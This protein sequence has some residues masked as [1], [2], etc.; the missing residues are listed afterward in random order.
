[1]D[2]IPDRPNVVVQFLGKGQR[3]AHEATN[4]LS[5]RVVHALH[6]VGLTALLAHG[7]MAFGR[8]HRPIRLPE[9]AVANGTLPIDGRQRGPKPAGNLTVSCANRDADDLAGVPVQGK[10][11][12]LLLALVS[13]KGPQLDTFYVFGAKTPFEWLNS[14]DELTSVASCYYLTVTSAAFLVAAAHN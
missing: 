3:F 6:V 10:P 12:P 13:D 7:T 14:V 2:K 9:V 8:E 1:M 4:A 11:H 5:Q